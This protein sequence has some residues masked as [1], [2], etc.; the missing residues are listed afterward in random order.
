MSVTQ[1]YT[2]TYTPTFSVTWQYTT[3]YT[4]TLSVTPQKIITY[5]PIL[6]VTGQNIVRNKSP[7]LQHH[8]T[9]HATGDVH[10]LSSSSLLSSAW[11]KSIEN[12]QVVVESEF[13]CGH[14]AKFNPTYPK[15]ITISID[16]ILAQQQEKSGCAIKSGAS[17]RHR[18]YYCSTLLLRAPTR[19]RSYYC[20]TLLL[21]APTRHRSYYCSTLLLK[22][23]T[24]TDHT[25]VPRSS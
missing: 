4:S 6:S 25:I 21:K 3:T 10:T 1:Q 9:D 18:S 5:T 13:L 14:I 11:S 19:H 15:L 8:R 20:S 22:E 2:T 17:T 12:Q 24:V 16:V 7:A 23:L